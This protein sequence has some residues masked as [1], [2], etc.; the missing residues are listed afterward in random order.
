VVCKLVF[1]GGGVWK[2][3]RATRTGCPLGTKR[4]NMTLS[5]Q[6]ARVTSKNAVVVV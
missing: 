5:E 6:E 4:R 2:Q 3:R 1:E